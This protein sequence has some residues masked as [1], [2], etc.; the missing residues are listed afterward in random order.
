MPIKVISLKR[1]NNTEGQNYITLTFTQQNMT[2]LNTFS[3]ENIPNIT[4][5]NTIT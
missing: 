2:Y 5:I 1:V 3:L 4:S